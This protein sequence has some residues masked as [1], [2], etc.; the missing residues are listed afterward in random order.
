MRTR[1][2]NWIFAVG[3]NKEAARAEGVPGGAHED[4]AVHDRLR[5]RRGSSAC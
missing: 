2:G 3:G 1:F 5:R 4:D